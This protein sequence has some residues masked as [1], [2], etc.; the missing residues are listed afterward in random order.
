MLPRLTID[1]II[2]GDIFREGDDMRSLPYRE[3][4]V[5]PKRVRERRPKFVEDI[6]LDYDRLDCCR[7]RACA[8]RKL[9]LGASTVGHTLHYK[10]LCLISIRGARRRSFGGLSTKPSNV[11]D[12]F[13]LGYKKSSKSIRDVLFILIFKVV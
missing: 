11:I 3:T 13:I 8:G 6:S 9:C 7:W 2:L 12:P 1:K 5:V 4:Y 10:R